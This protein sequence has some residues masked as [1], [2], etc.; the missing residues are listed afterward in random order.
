M[1]AFDVLLILDLDETLVF[2]TEEP[3][4][5]PPDFRS[6]DYAVYRRPGVEA[7]LTRCLA[8]FTVAV[9]TA[10]G[11]QYAEVVVDELFGPRRAEL[12]FFWTGERCTLRYDPE[13]M[14]WTKRKMLKK[15]WRLGY[16]REASLIVD[17]T[18]AT[19]EANFGNAVPVP[20]VEKRLWWRR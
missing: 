3:L 20:P 7:F 6:C 16:T 4:A 2:A 13:R 14:S 19:Y 1:P 11:R 10:S 18:E 9:W 12:V 8:D 17:N 5:R 15:V